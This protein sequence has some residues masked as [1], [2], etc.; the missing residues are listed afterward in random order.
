MGGTPT[1]GQPIAMGKVW[2]S[3]DNN[4]TRGQS[5][6]FGPNIQLRGTL[7]AERS[8][9][10]SPSGSATPATAITT[11]QVRLGTDFWNLGTPDTY[12]P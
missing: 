11:G 2:A 4:G 9:A 5:P 1:T 8:R 7:G 12:P 6:P 3:F 10:F